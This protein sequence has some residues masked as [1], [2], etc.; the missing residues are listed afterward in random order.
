MSSDRRLSR[1]DELLSRRRLY[2]LKIATTM[3]ENIELSDNG[4]ESHRI[5]QDQI[6]QINQI[7]GEQKRKMQPQPE[8]GKKRIGLRL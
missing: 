4:L 3:K 1:A 2:W 6:N 5:I 8:T 7:I